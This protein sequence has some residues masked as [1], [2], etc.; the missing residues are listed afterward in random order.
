MM[1]DLESRFLDL[2][3]QE[4][5]MF[6]ALLIICLTVFQAFGAEASFDQEHWR[7]S[8]VRSFNARADVK[9]NPKSQLT[10]VNSIQELQD[11]AFSDD[12]YGYTRLALTGIK[13][14]NL[15]AEALMGA[16]DTG[17]PA[18]QIN[19]N[20]KYK[21]GYK[22]DACSM[23]FGKYK[24]VVFDWAFCPEERGYSSYS[25]GGVSSFA[26]GSIREGTRNGKKTFL[27][28]FLGQD[29]PASVCIREN[30]RRL[31]G[32]IAPGP[33]VVVVFDLEKFKF[34]K[35]VGKCFFLTTG[36][37]EKK[38]WLGL[39][40]GSIMQAGTFPNHPQPRLRSQEVLKLYPDLPV[41]A[42]KKSKRSNPN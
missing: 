36:P 9:A 11:R 16:S 35:E 42:L 20:L 21:S 41:V 30:P 22:L 7:S 14:L 33:V 18:P 15:D 24:N 38:N 13:F 37:V 5:M 19:F 32:G 40:E 26:E 25:I 34:Q 4:R 27:A 8:C 3:N 23:A 1:R 29:F 17:T 2:I 31:I 28:R 39:P 6:A 10:C 12:N